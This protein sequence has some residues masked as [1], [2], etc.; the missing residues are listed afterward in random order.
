[1][2]FLGVFGVG[3]YN[4]F[5]YIAVQYTTA[6]SA[7]LLNSFIPVVTSLL[8]F[9]FLGKRLQRPEVSDIFLSGATEHGDYRLQ[10]DQENNR[11]VRVQFEALF[12]MQCRGNLKH[13]F[14]NLNWKFCPLCGSSLKRIN[15]PEK[16]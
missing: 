15:K 14:P 8:A 10:L 9:L 16:K 7:T 1:M 12:I 13:L 5:S 6:T 11:T 2:L 4:T 3:C